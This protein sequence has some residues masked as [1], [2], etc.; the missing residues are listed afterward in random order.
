MANTRSQHRRVALLLVLDALTL[1]TV[2]LAEFQDETSAELGSA[3]SERD[4]LKAEYAAKSAIN[5][6]RLLIAAEPTIRNSPGVGPLLMMAFRGQKPQI[7]VWA[8]ADKV[9][10]AF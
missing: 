4:A 6:S 7:P 1:L 3:L 2:M 5:L 9:L 8:F 10:G